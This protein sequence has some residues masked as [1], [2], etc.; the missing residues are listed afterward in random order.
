[1]TDA[2]LQDSGQSDS[3]SSSNT[4]SDILDTASKL[5]TS[6]VSTYKSLTGTTAA[7]AAGSNPLAS[8]TS[9]RAAATAAA[10]PFDWKKYLPWGL[11]AV[12]LLVIVGMVFRRK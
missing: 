7:G 9:A 6:G 2:E 8:N 11:G 10:A 5:A 12:V 3:S 1:M 4:L